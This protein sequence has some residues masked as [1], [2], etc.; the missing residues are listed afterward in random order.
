MAMLTVDADGHPLMSRM[1]RPADEKR[2]VAILRPDD[3]EEWL[4]TSNIEAARAMLQLY[5]AEEMV[6]EPK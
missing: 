4:V 2:S 3:W 5:P 6:D 1:H